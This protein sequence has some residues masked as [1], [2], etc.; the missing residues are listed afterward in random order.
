[1]RSFI[2]NVVPKS[3]G[4]RIP[5]TLA[6]QVMIDIQ[7]M[8]SDIGEYLIRRELGIQNSIDPKNMSR[9]ILYM[10]G[11]GGISIGTSTESQPIGSI[12]QDAID[13]MEETM[14]A[15]GSG[16][17]GYWMEDNYADPY[18]RNNIIYD[19]VALS[20]HVNSYPDCSFM[21][22]SPDNLKT[23]GK[24]DVVRLGNFIKEKG[25][26][27]NGASLGLITSTESK[28]KGKILG[29]ECGTDRV[30]LHFRDRSVE[31]VARGLVG[32]GCA[33]VVGKLMYSSE[34]RLLEIRDVYNIVQAETIR[35]RR[36][37]AP[38]ADVLL[39]EPLV[40]NISYDGKWHLRNDE[41][42]ISSTKD[43]WDE[44]VQAFNDYFVFLWTEYMMD[45]REL[46]GEDA[47]IRAALSKMM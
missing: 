3:E 15:M 22:G 20:E 13:L 31:N 14:D 38:E 9:F 11:D 8:L 16:T 32:K 24:V 25:M 19:I 34:G 30:K 41:L 42:G 2:V 7:Q 36:A 23:F 40:A 27:A 29:F 17:G 5:A 1:M 43:T 37:I 33:Y 47:E 18:F 45:E 44:A 10:D 21:Y 46:N 6:G 26:S 4:G 39:K 28:S 12:T 35:F